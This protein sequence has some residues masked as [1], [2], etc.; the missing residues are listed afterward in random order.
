[1]ALIDFRTIDFSDVFFGRNDLY[2]LA[3]FENTT[4]VLGVHPKK[5]TVRGGY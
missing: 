2:S 4:S 3:A 5:L 1:M